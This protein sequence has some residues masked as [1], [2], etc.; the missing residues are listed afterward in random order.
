MCRK[1]QII[2]EAKENHQ[3]NPM[4]EN[5]EDIGDTTRCLP[6]NKSIS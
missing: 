5:I 3:R 1:R 6:K 2:E 4:E